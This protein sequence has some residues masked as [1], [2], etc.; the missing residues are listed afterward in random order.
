MKATITILGLAFS[1]TASAQT[2]QA[3]EKSVLEEFQADKFL[4]GG[5]LTDYDRLPRKALTPLPRAM[6][7]TT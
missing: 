4:A 1:L 7:P 6:S 2:K 3:Y 5:N